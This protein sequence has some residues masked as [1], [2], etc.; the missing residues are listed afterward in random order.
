MSKQTQGVACLTRYLL[1]HYGLTQSNIAV[2]EDVA[3]KTE[4]EGE[5]EG[6]GQHTMLLNNICKPIIILSVTLYLL[7][8]KEETE[9]YQ[10][11]CIDADT[12]VKNDV[13]KEGILWS[14]STDDFEHLI[15]LVK[16]ES[17]RN[18]Y[19]MNSITACEMK[20]DNIQ[21]DNNICKITLNA[22]AYGHA[23]CDDESEYSFGCYEK[24]CDQ[25]FPF[26]FIDEKKTYS[27]P[28]FTNLP[29][30]INKKMYSKNYEDYLD[31]ISKQTIENK[32]AAK[33]YFENSNLNNSSYVFRY[34]DKA[35]PL[36]NS[37][38]EYLNGLT[39]EEKELGFETSNFG[40]DS[41]QVKIEK[42]TAF[43]NFKSSDLS[44]TGPEQ[45]LNFIYNISKTAEQ[46]DTVNKTEI[47][48]NNIYNY[49][50]AFL[51]N[52]EPIDCPFSF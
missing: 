2:H 27:E 42:N 47:C 20:F 5:G 7:A 19:V 36:K 17:S 35:S 15:S 9:V 18:I 29:D 10:T 25:Y 40:N 51:A 39:P 8:C 31:E 41:F 32:L 30:T 45:I 13:P 48:I 46:F 11:L 16:K 26:P 44:I 28:V 52:E 50:M 14:L 22:G 12:T 3:A 23:K 49:Q 34:I 43:V 4:G 38:Q 21:V 37:I 33:I 1:T 6:E 24:E